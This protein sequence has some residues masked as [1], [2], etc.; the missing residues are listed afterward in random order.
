MPGERL[1]AGCDA[2]GCDRVVGAPATVRL[3]VRTAFVTSAPTTSA[4][5]TSA[6]ATTSQRQRWRAG[7]AAAR[8]ASGLGAGFAGHP[9]STSEAGVR[10]GLGGAPPNACGN[11]GRIPE[12]GAGGIPGCGAGSVCDT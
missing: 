1:T 4:T 6:P 9:A 7:P 8:T 12:C 2:P 3:P 5:T 10:D 11:P